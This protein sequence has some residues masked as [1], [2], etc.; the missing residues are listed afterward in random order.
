MSIVGFT[1]EY[2]LAIHGIKSTLNNDINI[3]LNGIQNI[4]KYGFTLGELADDLLFDGLCIELEISIMKIYCGNC[5]G[6]YLDQ[7]MWSKYGFV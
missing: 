1:V 2:N 6:V 5:E 7:E 3:N 4:T